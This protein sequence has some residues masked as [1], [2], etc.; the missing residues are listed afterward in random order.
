MQEEPGPL[1]NRYDE[2]L[3]EKALSCFGSKK[4]QFI[5]FRGEPEGLGGTFSYFVKPAWLDTWISAT[6]FLSV[7]DVKLITGWTDAPS[8]DPAW[9]EG[10]FLPV[11]VPPALLPEW[12]SLR[13]SWVTVTGRFDGPE[14]TACTVDRPIGQPPSAADLVDM[15]RTSFVIT[16]IEATSRP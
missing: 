5:A 1:T 6:T 14:A 3:N 15:C 11:A 10:P 9:T 4:L 13:G 7:S 12:E 8:P 16:S 2:R